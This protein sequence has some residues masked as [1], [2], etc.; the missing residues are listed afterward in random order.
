MGVIGKKLMWRALAAANLPLANEFDFPRLQ[1]RAEEQ[2]DR[3]ETERIKAAQRVF[4][5]RTDQ[6]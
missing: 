1:R 5:N 2:R 3:R 6:D 4:A